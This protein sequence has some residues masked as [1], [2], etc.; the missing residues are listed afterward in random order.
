MQC[1][2][3]CKSCTF[4]D[5]NRCASCLDGLV[6]TLNEGE[7]VGTC[8]CDGYCKTCEGETTNCTSCKEGTFLEDNK[9][10][11]ECKIGSYGDL[12]T[13]KCEECVIAGCSN[14]SSATQCD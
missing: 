5:E 8:S 6:L 14:C 1:Y 3:T 4:S 2:E 13:R 10:V 12:E 11:G 9:C 7:V